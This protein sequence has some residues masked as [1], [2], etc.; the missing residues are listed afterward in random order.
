MANKR[1]VSI[2]ILQ[3]VSTFDFDPNNAPYQTAVRLCPGGHTFL[4]KILTFSN[5][6]ILLTI[7]SVYTKLGDFVNLDV[8]FQTLWIN[9][10]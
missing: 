1:T 9:G 3:K 10:C 7:R 4:C 6:C 8:L 5:G 2:F